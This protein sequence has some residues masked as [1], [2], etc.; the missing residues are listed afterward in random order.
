MIVELPGDYDLSAAYPNPFNPSTQFELVVKEAQE[1]KAEVYDMLG[2][3]VAV[4]HDGRM[5]ANQKQ[6]LRFEARTLA[7]GNYVLRVQ[8]E[9]FAATQT[10]M[11]V[12]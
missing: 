5:E 8:G 11:L 7:S 3:R 10:M 2:R 1:V 9:H 6:R 4:L 12:K